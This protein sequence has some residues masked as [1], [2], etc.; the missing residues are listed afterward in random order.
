MV[1]TRAGYTI[2]F[3]LSGWHVSAVLGLGRV[4]FIY[5]GVC[6]AVEHCTRRR[7]LNVDSDPIGANATQRSTKVCLSQRLS[8][9]LV[10]VGGT[11]RRLNAYANGRFIPGSGR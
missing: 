10:Q 9:V 7:I 5:N 2:R 8:T 6:L 1:A 3:W 11:E 4:L